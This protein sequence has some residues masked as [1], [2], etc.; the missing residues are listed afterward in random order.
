MDIM[1]LYNLGGREAAIERRLQRERS[2]RERIVM[3]GIKRGKKVKEIKK[4]LRAAGLLVPEN[5]ANRWIR[6]Y[7]WKMS[8]GSYDYYFRMN[9][10]SSLIGECNVNI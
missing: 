1:N 8:G 5:W 3:Q 7:K 9:K 2:L 4:D 10:I 6:F